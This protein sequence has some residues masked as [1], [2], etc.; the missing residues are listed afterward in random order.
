[1]ENLSI[2]VNDAYSLEY[3]ELLIKITNLQKDAKQC[4]QHVA[5]CED[6]KMAYDLIQ[7]EIVRLVE[8]CEGIRKI[9]T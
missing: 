1:M 5:T 9:P 2:N 3:S 8:R 6:A 7:Y 4:F